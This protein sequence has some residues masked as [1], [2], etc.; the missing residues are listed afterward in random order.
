MINRKAQEMSLTTLILLVLGIIILIFV[1][2]GFT[3]GLGKISKHFQFGKNITESN[4]T[5]ECSIAPDG[6]AEL[7]ASGCRIGCMVF[8]NISNGTIDD[9]QSC[10]L[11]CDENILYE[12]V[13]EQ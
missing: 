12:G 7:S 8:R 9:S 4:N 13:C 3:G 1:I 6:Y 5:I 2:L 10:R 11:W